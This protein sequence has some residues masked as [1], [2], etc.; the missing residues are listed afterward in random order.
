S[1]PVGRSSACRR[2]R[3][4]TGP[5]SAN[6]A[7]APGRRFPRSLCE[8]H[9]P[10]ASGLPDVPVP[11]GSLP[12]SPTPNLAGT[13]A[14]ADNRPMGAREERPGQGLRLRHEDRQGALDDDRP[15]R[16]QLLPC[17]HQGHADYRRGATSKI[18]NP[19]NEIVAYSLNA[20]VG[21]A[22]TQQVAPS[23]GSASSGTAGSSASANGRS[24][25]VKGGEF[26][27]RLSTKTAA[28]PGKV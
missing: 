10:S 6:P 7:C 24:V 2:T 15:G 4:G 22:K 18:K 5:G 1:A 19:Q 11:R 23:T 3:T 25:Q 20:P 9:L 28:K 8:R 16:H 27:F 21:G 17:G 26:F 13:D 12:G 14:E